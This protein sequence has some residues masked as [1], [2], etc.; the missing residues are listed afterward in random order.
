M[1]C[2]HVWGEASAERPHGARLTINCSFARVIATY[3]AL[4]CSRS[5]S[6]CSVL[7]KSTSDG[8]GRVA[9]RTNAT[10]AGCDKCCGQST[11]KAYVSAWVRVGWVSTK[12][13]TLASRPLA[14]WM[15]SN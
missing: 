6:C 2:H 7:I 4:K 10:H 13:T 12:N 11:A 5:C 3:R 14:P 9:E 1:R 8:G 15:V